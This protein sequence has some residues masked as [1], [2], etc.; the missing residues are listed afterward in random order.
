[1]LL[2]IDHLAVCAENLSTGAAF[3]K[4]AL[5]VAPGPGGR[6]PQMG[7]HNRLLSLGP[8][9]YL[10]VI[11]IDPK[12]AAPGRA[13]WFDLDNFAGA[14]RLSNWVARAGDID[15]A[16]RAAPRGIGKV[17]ALARD[18]LRWQMAVPADGRLPFGG[19]FP[20]LISWGDAG[21]PAARLPDRGCRLV[22]LRLCHPRGDALRARLEPLM[23]MAQ[24]RITNA[25]QIRLEADIMTPA[26]L[27]VLR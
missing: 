16:V 25:R 11:A 14:P 18:D 27:R 23:N 4:S 7:T 17:M 20:G 19:A 22:Q 15:A 6:H 1:M 10:E 26:G 13:R 9:V 3:V 24:V 2:A 21:H 5:G 12:A 8:E